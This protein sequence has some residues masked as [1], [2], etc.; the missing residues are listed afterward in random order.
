M[1]F[2]SWLTRFRAEQKRQYGSWP[3]TAGFLILGL[4]LRTV[5]CANILLAGWEF[6]KDMLASVYHFK[7]SF[8]IML[9]KASK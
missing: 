7:E 5:S 1:A 3:F 2:H 8:T 9:I 6:G 4:I